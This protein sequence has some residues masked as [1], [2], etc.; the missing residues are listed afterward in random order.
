MEVDEE[1][2]DED[3]DEDESFEA[4]ESFHHLPR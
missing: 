4:G 3:D 1:E 2:D